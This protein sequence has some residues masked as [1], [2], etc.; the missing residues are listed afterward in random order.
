MKKFERIAAVLAIAAIAAA[1]AIGAMGPKTDLGVSLRHALPQA[2]EFKPHADRIYAGY[3]GDRPTGYV[4]ITQANGYGGPM[5]TAVGLDMSGNITGV[6]IIEHKETLPFFE[7]IK[8]AAYAKTLVGKSCKDPFA[9]GSDIDAV[10]GATVSLDAL[11]TSVRRGAR[12][13]AS[14]GLGLEVETETAELKFGL[15]EIVLILLFAVGL[16]TYSKPLVRRPTGRKLVRWLTRLGGLAMIGFVLAIPLSILNINSLVLGYWP[17]W[18]ISIYWYLMIVGVFLP[19]ILANKTVYCECICP[20][21]AAQD[22]LK[23]A[24]RAKRA[25]PKRLRIILR[26]VQRLLALSAIVAAL[27]YRNPAQFDYEVFGS[28]FTLTGTVVQLSLLGVVLIA[29]LFLVRPWCNFAC[30]VRAVGDYARLWPAWAKEVF[31]KQPSA[32]KA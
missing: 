30:P 4:A 31:Q 25:V 20:F 15:P 18:R 1:W 6:S 9:P 5:R 26:W 2:S 22:I 24:A 19:L 21:G 17:D 11:T 12:Q 14:K 28:F 27:L 10:S 32:P 7:R 29:S 23:T 13:A 16:L 3:D 8:V